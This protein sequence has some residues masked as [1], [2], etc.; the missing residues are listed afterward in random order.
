MGLGQALALDPKTLPH[1]PG[2]R[3]QRQTARWARDDG[4]PAGAITDGILAGDDSAYEVPD[5]LLGTG[6]AHNLFTAGRNEG[7]A[8][9]VSR[10]ALSRKTLSPRSLL[11]HD[12]AQPPLVAGSGASAGYD[13]EIMDLAGRVGAP[14]T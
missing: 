5:G 14:S 13:L 3:T 8:A 6:F 12:D 11:L 4:P 10:A 2:C 1:I 7:M 9:E